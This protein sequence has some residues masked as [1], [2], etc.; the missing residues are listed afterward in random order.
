[1]SPS[2][3]EAEGHRAR[4]V[5]SI[6][7]SRSTPTTSTPRRCSSLPTRPVLQLVTRTSARTDPP[8]SGSVPPG[9]S[10]RPGTPRGRLL[11]WRVGRGGGRLFELP[12]R[13]CAKCARTPE[14]HGL[15]PI[16]ISPAPLPNERIAVKVPR[17]QHRRLEAQLNSSAEPLLLLSGHLCPIET[18][19]L[20]DSQ[21]I[22][23]RR[24]ER[25]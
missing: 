4:A 11:P 8:D 23:R 12:N 3:H 10:R 22:C 15:L 7:A 5:S 19:V 6:S 24:T 1:M 25:A 14:G 18:V 16:L 2:I 17:L 13:A 20:R 9:D 21:S